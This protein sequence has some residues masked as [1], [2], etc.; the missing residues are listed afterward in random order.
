M[1]KRDYP[2]RTH[3]Y[4]GQVDL[5]IFRFCR[6]S[7]IGKAVRNAIRRAQHFRQVAQPAGLIE[8]VVLFD[9]CEKK[10]RLSGQ[11]FVESPDTDPDEYFTSVQQAGV[12]FGAD[13]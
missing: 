8:L 11:P 9:D 7:L 2:Y 3:I 6:G 12:D 4:R 5:S 10:Y 13:R 1:R